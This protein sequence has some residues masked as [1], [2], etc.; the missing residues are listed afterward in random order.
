MSTAMAQLRAE[1][2]IT[3][4]ALTVCARTAYDL[5]TAGQP[6]QAKIV[7]KGLIAA[8]PANA[9]YRSLYATALL[10]TREYKEALAVVDQGLTHTPG[11]AELLALRQSLLPIAG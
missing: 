11:H 3:D 10:R 5:L 4:D 8:A 7:A 2:G 1:L 9:Y 6:E